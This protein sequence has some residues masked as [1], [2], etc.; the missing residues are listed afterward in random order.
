MLQR[1]LILDII[2]RKTHQKNIPV[3][4][5]LSH[6]KNL[7]G[8]PNNNETTND[9][10][11]SISNYIK[12]N[13]LIFNQLN[14]RIRDSEITRAIHLL[15]NNKSPETDGIINEFLKARKEILLPCI[16]KLFNSIFNS[17]IYPSSW[18]VNTVT[19]IYKNGDRSEPINYRGIAVSSSLSKLFCSVLNRR[20][21]NCLYNDKNTHKSTVDHILSLKTLTEIKKY[22]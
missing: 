17:G 3:K 2:K 20:L 13:Q 19:P 8:E 15:K 1:I 7:M 16:T 18:H 14:F 9:F 5:W 21:S 4:E 22:I 6:F 12:E 11:K 10:D